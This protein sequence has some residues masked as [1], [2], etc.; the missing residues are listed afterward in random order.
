MYERRRG[1]LAGPTHAQARDS[2]ASTALLDPRSLSH[3]HCRALVY[4]VELAGLEASKS[5][6][7]AADMLAVQ[8]HRRHCPLPC[9]LRQLGLYSR[10][11]SAQVQFHYHW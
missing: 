4:T 6:V 11:I 5:V 1:S 3:G 2:I 7:A 9:A 10:A 8:P